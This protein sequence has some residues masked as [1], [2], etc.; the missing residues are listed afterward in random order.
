MFRTCSLLHF[1]LSKAKGRR[2]CFVRHRLRT[3]LHALHWFLLINKLRVLWWDL[4]CRYCFNFIF[5]NCL[6]KLFSTF[7]LYPR[8]FDSLFLR[9]S[10][11]NYSEILCSL[12]EFKLIAQP[13]GSEMVMISV[14]N[15]FLCHISLRRLRW[16]GL[17]LWWVSSVVIYPQSLVGYLRLVSSIYIFETPSFFWLLSWDKRGISF[18]VVKREPT[19]FNYRFLRRNMKLSRGPADY[20]QELA[21]FL[22][23]DVCLCHTK[24]WVYNIGWG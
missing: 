4:S 15:G 7:L 16:L 2:I 6:K 3:S 20:R 19:L 5:L 17:P 9:L 11:H 23:N 8:C 14:I 13:L 18:R 21:W 24:R 10:V 1:L 12:I 22:T